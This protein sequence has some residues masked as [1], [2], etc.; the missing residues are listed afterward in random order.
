MDIQAIT[1]TEVRHLLC[2]FSEDGCSSFL[3]KLNTYQ[4]TRCHIPD[5]RNLKTVFIPSVLQISIQ[6][7][8]F[9]SW[10]CALIQV[11]VAVKNNNG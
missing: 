10:I 9:I 11:R 7:T 4:I 1:L 8:I 5:D 2:I 3:C 6:Q